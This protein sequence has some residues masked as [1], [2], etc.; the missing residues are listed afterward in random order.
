[1]TY[2][3]HSKSVKKH[4]KI[5]WVNEKNGYE[6]KY[7]IIK[8]QR[9]WTATDLNV[10]NPLSKWKNIENFFQNEG[11]KKKLYGW[12]YIEMDGKWVKMKKNEGFNG[13]WL[14]INLLNSMV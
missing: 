14:I 7:E 12:K 5:R 6:E 11:S 2:G 3:N 4:Q 9:I 10:P 8:T 13:F 1:M